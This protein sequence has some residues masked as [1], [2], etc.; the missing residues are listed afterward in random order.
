MSGLK[1]KVFMPIV[2]VL[3]LLVV[4]GFTWLEVTKADVEFTHNGE[5]ETVVTRAQTVEALLEELEIQL[6]NDD[7]LSHELTTEITSDMSIEY[8]E[9]VEVVVNDD[10][11]TTTY[12]TT[13]DTVGEFLQEEAITLQSHD[14]LSVDE[15]AAIEDK[16]TLDIN[17]AVKVTVTDGTNESEEVYTTEETVKDLL[18][19]AAIE[20]SELDRVEP[21]VDEAIKEDMKISVIRVEE[22]TDVVEEVVAFST[23]RRNDSSIT[24][25]KEEVVEA[26]SNGLIEKRYTVVMENG[27]EVSRELES[28][29]VKKEASQRIVAV[30]TKVIQQAPSRGTS[31]SKAVSGKTIT[32]E[33]TAYNWN[34]ATCDGRGL[35]ATGYNLK[36]NP[37][38]VIAVDPSVIP[39][40]TRVYVEGYGYAV[41]RD[42]GGAIKGNKIDLHMR[43]V[44]AARQFGRRTVKLTIV[45]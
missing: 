43:S 36:A 32:M 5:T 19:E 12:M 16:L 1:H 45:E 6:G 24:K 14:V 25:G 35:T 39:L 3:L 33:A 42:T 44:S 15:A 31:S 13:A 4:V 20:L 28:E 23:V 40:G 41:A 22:V 30:G 34:C 2:T 7:Y 8:K 10:A 26:G 9:A 37:D 11:Q 18:D 17:R 27:K 38:G 29:E 21:S